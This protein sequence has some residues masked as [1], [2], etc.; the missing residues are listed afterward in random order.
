MH[1]RIDNDTEFP[2]ELSATFDGQT[3]E[4]VL[5]ARASGTFEIPGV[6]IV[7]TWN[8]RTVTKE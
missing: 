2:L 8:G 1:L 5:V 4:W 6:K 3:T 7:F